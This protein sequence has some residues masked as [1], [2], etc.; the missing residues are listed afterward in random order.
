MYPNNL[1]A[2]LRSGEIIL[3]TSLPAPSPLVAGVVLDTQPD[4]LWADTEHAP[5]ATEALDAILVL[6]RMRGVAPMVRVAWNDPALIKKAY[7]AGAVAV[8]V[9]QVDTAEEAALAVERARYAPQ[10]R[11]G[12]SPMWTKIAGTDWN[13]V[14]KTA[15]E[16]TLVVVQLESQRAYD[17][18]DAIKQVPGIDVIFVG[19]LDLSATV[20]TITNTGS[21]QVQQIMEDVPQRLE[22][23]GIAAGTTLMN[24]AEI[25]EKIRWGYRFL[26][27]GNAL[28]YGAQV[29]DDHL[30]TLR[31]NPRGDK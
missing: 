27:V 4:F 28:G 26:N 22:G 19:P 1:K 23:T 13:E 14:I 10:G 11:R 15:N 29:L 9:P 8:M 20:G 16:E 17:N 18:L 12:L 24:V 30:A 5:H 7:D 6:A 2:R 31:A 21:R 3:G 25:Q